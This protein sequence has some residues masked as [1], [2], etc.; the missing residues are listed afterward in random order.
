MLRQAVQ[1]GSET[2]SLQAQLNILSDTLQYGK[3]GSY[4]DNDRM[5]KLKTAFCGPSKAN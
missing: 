4:T 3:L 2:Y 1:P 5:S